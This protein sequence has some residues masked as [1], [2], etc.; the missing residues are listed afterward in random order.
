VGNALL[1]IGKKWGEE[2]P[3]LNALIV[4][5]SGLKKGIPGKGCDWYLTHFL[6]RDIKFEKLPVEDKRA[7]V[8]EVHDAIFAYKKWDKVQS[9][10]SDVI[11][12]YPEVSPFDGRFLTIP[13][14]PSHSGDRDA[15]AVPWNF[16]PPP[17]YRAPREPES[18]EHRALKEYVADHPECVGLPKYAKRNLEWVFG[19]GDRADVAFS[20]GDKIVVVEVKSQVSDDADMCKGVFQCIKY[21]VRAHQKLKRVV[22]N[23]DAILALGKKAPSKLDFGQ[24]LKWRMRGMPRNMG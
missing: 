4:A 17:R 18:P 11:K 19:S 23:G 3:P 22:P 2:I 24:F 13:R 8:D 5:K 9:Y 10:V 16:V 14:P 15:S 6:D 1:E 20:L 7:I 12:R 21:R